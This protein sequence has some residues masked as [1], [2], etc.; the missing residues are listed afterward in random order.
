MQAANAPPSRLQAK[1]AVS[2]AVNAI[3][4]A[5]P[6][7]GGTGGVML[8]AGAVVSTVQGKES[9]LVSSAAFVAWTTKVCDPA[10]TV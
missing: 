9:V 10:P 2:V 5:E 6:V 7:V 3:E 1:V 8:V 4:T